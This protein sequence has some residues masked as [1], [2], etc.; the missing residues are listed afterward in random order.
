MISSS[1]VLGYVAAALVL[2][3]FYMRE[4][5]PLRITAICSNIAFIAYGLALGLAPVWLLHALLLPMNGYRLLEALR[6]RRTSVRTTSE[7]V[8]LGRANGSVRIVRGQRS[9]G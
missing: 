8:R 1:D 4:M 7:I 5:I 6:A 3:A 9:V 2:S